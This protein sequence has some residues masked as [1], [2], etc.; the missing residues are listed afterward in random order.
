LL[1]ACFDYGIHDCFLHGQ[2]VVMYHSDLKGV[3]KP[4][5]APCW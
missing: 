5:T 2:N 3:K 4:P 1:A